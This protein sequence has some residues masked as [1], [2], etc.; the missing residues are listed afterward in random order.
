MKAEKLL[1]FFDFGHDRLVAERLLHGL[2]GAAAELKIHRH[3]HT[4]NLPRP[5]DRPLAFLLAE[6]TCWDNVAQLMAIRGHRC[7]NDISLGH[8]FEMTVIEM[9]LNVQSMEAT[10]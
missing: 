7:E 10:D 4:R 6:G 2:H 9:R 1:G 5:G 8:G 3:C